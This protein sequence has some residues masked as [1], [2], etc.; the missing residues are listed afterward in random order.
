[1]QWHSHSQSTTKSIK[2]PADTETDFIVHV[3]AEQEMKGSFLLATTVSLWATFY[4][5]DIKCK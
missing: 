3:S 1:M 4:I 2:N 5:E